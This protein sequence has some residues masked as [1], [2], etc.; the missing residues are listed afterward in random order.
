MHFKKQ[1]F[2]SIADSSFQNYTAFD[3]STV[4]VQ[5]SSLGYCDI[6]AN[7]AYAQCRAPANGYSGVYF[8]TG[9][10]PAKKSDISLE[11]IIE[12][13]LE[14]TNSAAVWT[15]PSAGVY[16]N[17][18][19]YVVKNIGDADVTI[20]EVGFFSSYR[21]GSTNYMPVLFE[22]TVLA[23]PIII[24]PGSAKV[25]TYKLTFNQSQ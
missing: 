19:T 7:I 22:R 6:G 2:V 24:S 18:A 14:I 10:T 13:G 20:S 21:N 17:S 12:T 8:G 23:S 5:S 25:I 11:N 1:L 4:S 9:T 3:G 15:E 16:E